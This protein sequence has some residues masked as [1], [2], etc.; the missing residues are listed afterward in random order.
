LLIELGNTEIDGVTI[1]RAV[2]GG[3][4]AQAN[5]EERCKSLTMQCCWEQLRTP[6]ANKIKRLQTKICNPFSLC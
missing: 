3:A 4:I 5:G 2:A 1:Q 6:A